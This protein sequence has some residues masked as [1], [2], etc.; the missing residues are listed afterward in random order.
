MSLPRSTKSE[1]KL[2][3]E[4]VKLYPG[5]PEAPMGSWVARVMHTNDK[6]TGFDPSFADC[7]RFVAALIECDRRN[8]ADGICSMTASVMDGSFP[9]YGPLR[10]EHKRKDDGS[11][12]IHVRF[13]PR[14]NWMYLRLG[15]VQDIWRRIWDCEYAAY[16][17]HPR[18]RDPREKARAYLR[19]AL[20]PGANLDDLDRKHLIPAPRRAHGRQ[21]NAA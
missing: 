6:A 17:N 5:R 3:I 7:A 16:K 19:E 11:E 10:V 21:S 18:V 15:E 4:L 8:R 2:S 12:W 14:T 20:E 13:Y 9:E 1:R